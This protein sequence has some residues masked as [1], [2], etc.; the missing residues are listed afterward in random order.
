METRHHLYIALMLAHLYNTDNMKTALFLICLILI[1]FAIK[2]SKADEEFNVIETTKLTYI[3]NL[4]G[5]V[6]TNYEIIFA[7]E[8]III[9]TNNF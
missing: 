6:L 1:G 3:T 7:K 9:S 8:P 5:N 4:D 2:P